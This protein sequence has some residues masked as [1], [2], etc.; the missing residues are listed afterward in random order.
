MVL[1]HVRLGRTVPPRNSPHLTG[2]AVALNHEQIAR[3]QGLGVQLTP[4]DPHHQH[5]R[6]VDLSACHVC[7]AQIPDQRAI[8]R[9]ASRA[10]CE[11]AGDIGDL[12]EQAWRYCWLW[13]SRQPILE[14]PRGR[15]AC[16]ARARLR[17]P[18]GIAQRDRGAGDLLPLQLVC[19]VAQREPAK[20]VG[21]DC[22]LVDPL[23]GDSPEMSG[24]VE[25]A[26]PCRDI[27]RR[28][29]AH[30]DP[31]PRHVVRE[32]GGDRMIDKRA[33]ADLDKAVRTVE[34]DVARDQGTSRECLRIRS[35]LLDVV[36]DQPATGR[37]V[38][39]PQVPYDAT[40]RRA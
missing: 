13:L 14:P 28:D 40:A 26:Q 38:V 6:E 12:P 5:V 29:D 36:E 35:H 30:V 11:A 2:V 4:R 19:G 31:Q 18:D 37:D 7:H 9:G 1:V 25:V 27:L 24:E 17:S 32:H 15:A 10:E 22:C 39:G 20:A 23:P 8:A 34:Q 3:H 33:L 16:H 21:A